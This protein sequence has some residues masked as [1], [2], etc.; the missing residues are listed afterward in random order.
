M[1]TDCELNC[2]N[3]PYRLQEMECAEIFEDAL[4][5]GGVGPED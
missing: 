2:Q 5:S 3:C 4:V 1:M